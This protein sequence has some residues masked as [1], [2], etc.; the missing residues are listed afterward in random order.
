MSTTMKVL[1]HARERPRGRCEQWYLLHRLLGRF[2][3]LIFN[4]FTTL[5]RAQE[6]LSKWG[7]ADFYQ[8]TSLEAGSILIFGQSQTQCSAFEISEGEVRMRLRW[9]P[10]EWT[11][12][13][14]R[15]SVENSISPHNVHERWFWINFYGHWF[16]RAKFIS[17]N[18][19]ISHCL[20][21][22]WVM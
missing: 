5:P 22:R 4:V 8:W 17:E 9:G 20:N 11:L 13:T 16:R 21:G 1:F 15:V 7:V 12:E 10:L 14:G 19:V 3:L 6:I 2:K 18:A